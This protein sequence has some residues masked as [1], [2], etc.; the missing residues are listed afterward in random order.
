M[1][2]MVVNEIL[3]CQQLVGDVMAAGLRN[4]VLE[5]RALTF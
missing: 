5:H 4:K 2:W 1:G 3:H